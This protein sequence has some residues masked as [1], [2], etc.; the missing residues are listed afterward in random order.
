MLELLKMQSHLAP[1]HP[2]MPLPTLKTIIT[3]IILPALG[4]KPDA[5]LKE[6]EKLMDHLENKEELEE[7]SLSQIKTQPDTPVHLELPELAL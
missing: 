5:R 2:Q 6:T 7:G 3:I 4:N 1:Q